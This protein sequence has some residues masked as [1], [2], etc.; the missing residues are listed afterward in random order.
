MTPRINTHNTSE[1]FHDFKDATFASAYAYSATEYHLAKR[2]LQEQATTDW[3]LERQY[4]E[5]GQRH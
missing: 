2:L 1:A 3:Y 4:R 5:D